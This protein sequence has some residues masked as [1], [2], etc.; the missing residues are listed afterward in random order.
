MLAIGP[1]LKLRMPTRFWRFDLAECLLFVRTRTGAKEQ[2]LLSYDAAE[3]H[4]R[5]GIRMAS[6]EQFTRCMC[7]RLRRASL[8][9]SVSSFESIAIYI[10]R[11]ALGSIFHHSPVHLGRID[12]I[13]PSFHRR[14]RVNRRF[15]SKHNLSRIRPLQ[16]NVFPAGFTKVR[17]RSKLGFYALEQGTTP[18]I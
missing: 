2:N 10:L 6:S 17:K 18:T 16:G 14:S 11:L 3:L 5:T 13:L 9:C 7:Y 15:L 1:Q 4:R 8:L 12:S